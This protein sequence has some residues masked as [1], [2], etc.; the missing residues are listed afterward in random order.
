MENYI[1]AA[2]E[3]SLN[4][5]RKTVQDK[6]PEIKASVEMMVEAIRSGNKIMVCGNGGS[7]SDA[8]HICGE[9]TNRLLKE[10]RPLP[11][12][13]LSGDVASIT[14]IGNDYSFNEVFSKQVEAFGNNGDILWVLTTSGNSENL[15]K[16][17]SVAKKSGI[18][19]FSFS[20]KSGG[21]IVDLSDLSIVVE[22]GKNSP[23][24]QETHSFLYH[25]IIELIE[26]T[27][28]EDK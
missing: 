3:E 13:P 9:F 14:A 27:L 6:M 1:N 23:R 26:K 19:V 17:A 8:L 22:S 10:R 25:V 4:V 11:A 15:L 7:A 16:A 20:G 28:F 21:A 18:K 24:I 5:K 12:M 2:L